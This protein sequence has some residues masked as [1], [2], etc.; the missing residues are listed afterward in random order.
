MGHGGVRGGD[1]GAKEHAQAPSE[2]FRQGVFAAAGS[3]R[4][5]FVVRNIPHL[6][7][8]RARRAEAGLSRSYVDKMI[9]ET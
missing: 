6:L 9:C 3:P 1:V 4:V 7:I 2:I 5:V 8:I